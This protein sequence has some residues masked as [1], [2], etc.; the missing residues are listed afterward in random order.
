MANEYIAKVIDND[1]EDKEGKVQIYIEALMH[2]FKPSDYPWARQDK[3]ATSAIPEKDDMIWVYYEDEVNYR[4]PY[5]KNKLNLEKYH[6]H[7]KYDDEVKSSTGGSAEYPDVK[8]IYF[9]NG[10]CIAVSS[11]DS[12]PEITIH[13]PMAYIFIDKIGKMEIKTPMGEITGGMLTINGAVA[14]T[15]SGPFCALPTCLFTGSVHIGNK[16]LGT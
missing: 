3:G 12:K 14:P 9:E 11:S 7:D 10:V 13:H 5:Y 8:Y 4:N 16:I 2:G 1:D 6:E 15:G